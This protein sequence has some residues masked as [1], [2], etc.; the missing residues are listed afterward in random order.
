MS[1][2][3]K[4]LSGWLSYRGVM[5]RR[6]FWLYYIVI[7]A[8][9]LVTQATATNLVIL[10][11]HSVMLTVEIASGL[12]TLCIIASLGAFMTRRLRDSGY[13]WWPLALLAASLALLFFGALRD[14]ASFAPP[15][16]ADQ[17]VPAISLTTQVGFLSSLAA[18]AVV[19]WGLTR[20]SRP[21]K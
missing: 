4:I 21:T 19:F 8:A 7:C 13:G 15:S 16:S 14:F 11:G 6:E 5:T 12:V 18:A 2:L 9:L 3:V 17:V 10:L 20:P 1:R